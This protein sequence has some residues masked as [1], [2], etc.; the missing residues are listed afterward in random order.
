MKFDYEKLIENLNEIQNIL[1][2]ES[3]PGSREIDC[4]CL[5]CKLVADCWDIES[6]LQDEQIKHGT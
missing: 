3:H 5:R 6:W 1:S 4:T 2:G